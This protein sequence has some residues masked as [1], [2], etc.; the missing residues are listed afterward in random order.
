MLQ[1]EQEKTQTQQVL[2]WEVSL[3]AFPFF[4]RLLKV[5][6]LLFSILSYQRRA[7]LCQNPP[8]TSAV[9]APPAARVT[10]PYNYIFCSC[11]SRDLVT[12]RLA[13]QYPP[14]TAVLIHTIIFTPFP[15]QLYRFRE[16]S[17][18]RASWW[19]CRSNAGLLATR[20]TAD[21]VL[22]ER[23]ACGACKEAGIDIRPMQLQNTWNLGRPLRA[24]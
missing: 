2:D 14:H 23:G 17:Q 19:C 7:H 11:F 15:S 13:A 4:E 3:S 1:W 18:R 8:P 6:A 22:T 21:P 16:W 10:V 20:K 9:P 12:E 24:R 5:P